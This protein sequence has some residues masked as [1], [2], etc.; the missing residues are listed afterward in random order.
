[1]NNYRFR[2]NPISLTNTG[3]TNDI[4]IKIPISSVFDFTGVNESIDEYENE[5]IRASINPIDDLETIRYSHSAWRGVVHGPANNTSINYEFY[6]YSALTNSSV[7][8]TT[9]NDNW[10]IDY[11]AN[12]YTNQQI[13]YYENVFSKSYFKLDFYDSTKSTSQQILLTI[14]IPV[15][16]GET[17][18]AVIGQNIVKIRKPKFSLNHTG[19]KEGYYVYW[20]K[21]RDF[22]DAGTL[23]MSCKY[24]DA[25]IGQFKRMI[26]QPQGTLQNKFNFSQEEYFYYVLKLDYDTYEYQVFDNEIDVNSFS[27]RR[28]TGTAP[29]KWYEYVNP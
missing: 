16:Q 9:N 14:I 28:G 17:L 29:I 6:F 4:G 3:A 10:V 20:L 8:A 21:N 25:G 1:M 2:Y 11:R 23:Y 18:D 5:I 12:G 27:D 24:Y 13:Y 15:Q 22:I 26:K 7:T 19:D